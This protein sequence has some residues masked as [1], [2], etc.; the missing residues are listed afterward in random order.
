MSLQRYNILLIAEAG[1]RRDNLLFSKTKKGS[2]CAVQREE[3][4]G[5]LEERRKKKD[6]DPKVILGLVG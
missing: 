3:I 4:A 6:N 2:Y 5:R 1:R